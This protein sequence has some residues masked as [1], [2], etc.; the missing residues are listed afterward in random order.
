MTLPSFPPHGGDQRQLDKVLLSGFSW[1]AFARI[2]GQVV[3]WSSTFIVVRLLSPSD[4]GI[5]AMG[6]VVFGIAAL[7]GDGGL[8]SAILNQREVREVRLGQLTSVAVM[9]GVVATMLGLL[10]AIPVSLFFHEP[11]LKAVVGAASLAYLVTGFRVVPVA[12]LQR[13]LAFRFLARNDFLMVLTTAI[14]SVSLA[15]LGA[16]Y[17]ALIVA[18][19]LGTVVATA[20]AW[21]ARPQRLRKPHWGE[22]RD[23]LAF[24]GHLMTSRMAGYATGQAD[25][26]IIGR[27]LSQQLLGAYR[28]AM[29]IASIPVDKVA[30]LVLQVTTPVLAAVRGDAA[31]TGRYLLRITEVIAIVVWPMAIGLALTADL[32]VDVVIGSQWQPAVTPLRIFAIVAALRC[33]APLLSAVVLAAGNAR[34]IGRIS[35]YSTA[36][37]IPLMLSVRSWGLPALATVAALAFLIGTM[38]VLRKALEVT[39]I[40]VQ[41]YLRALLPAVG[42][43]AV[44]VG[45]VISLRVLLPSTFS[46]AGVLAVLVLGGGLAYAGTLALTARARVISLAKT[47]RSAARGSTSSSTLME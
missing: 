7:L 23:T 3:A 31:A 33:T 30:A 44:M 39:G 32:L 41:A 16:G 12:V 18:P 5:V 11:R 10:L 17:W 36:I 27:F 21:H 22:L 13:D 20:S 40:S 46:N 34:L 25:S 45:V 43:C 15:A 14:I 24:G 8:G 28:V 47:I 2:L 26:V 42:S 19:I 6:G 37:A 1:N 38:L 9:L 29:D 4:Y 35:L